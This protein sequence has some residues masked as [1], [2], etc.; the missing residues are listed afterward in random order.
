M[1]HWEGDRGQHRLEHGDFFHVDGW[2]IHAKNYTSHFQWW[3]LHQV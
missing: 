3:P 2:T 1:E